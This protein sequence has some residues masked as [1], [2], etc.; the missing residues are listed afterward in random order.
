MKTLAGKIIIAV[1]ALV[2][3]A[4]VAVNFIAGDSILFAISPETYIANL[5]SNTLDG[6]ELM[7]YDKD[8]YEALYG[9]DMT[10]EDHSAL[11]DFK[12]NS[13]TVDGETLDLDGFG[14][15]GKY[16]MSFDKN[17]FALDYDFTYGDKSAEYMQYMHSD[18]EIALSFFG[19][20]LISINARDIL[21]DW[22]ASALAKELSSPALPEG[23][24]DLAFSKLFEDE[25]EIKLPK[26]LLAK[27]GDATVDFIAKSDI[28][29][30]KGENADKI[31][32]SVDAK[33]L[34]EYLV[35][36]ADVLENDASVKDFFRDFYGIIALIESE[37]SDEYYAE[38][39]SEFDL[40]YNATFDDLKVAITDTFFAEEMGDDSYVLDFYE[41]NKKLEG[42]TFTMENSEESYGIDISPSENGVVIA[43][44]QDGTEL[45][46]LSLG[47]EANITPDKLEMYIDATAGNSFF[48]A[49]GLDYDIVYDFENE[50]FSI[51][52]TLGTSAEAISYSITGTCS[53]KENLIINLES[54]TMS[55]PDGE[56]EI[57]CDAKIEVFEG[58]D[59]SSFEQKETVK[60]TNLTSADFEEYMLEGEERLN[61][62]MSALTEHIMEYYMSSYD[63]YDDTYEDDYEYDGYDF[64][65]YEDL[66]GEDEDIFAQYPEYYDDAYFEDF[67][68]Q[69]YGA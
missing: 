58:A 69:Y 21:S 36:L 41:K 48:A 49:A 51:N 52:Y 33:A 5:V 9:F 32:V 37:G 27:L 3:V 8:A 18:D 16:A 35:A 2:V 57:D 29:R 14:M 63:F 44:L 56:I 30:E 24:L 15:T 20:D 17:L 66:Y 55:T 67:Y 25:Y 31:T 7:L 68:N 43:L 60:F 65:D 19:G 4:G 28:T 1:V 39:M 62:I 53:N 59:L 64:Y 46:Q 6:E 13:I 50:V 45:M 54:I 22:N 23:K 26:K 38:T 12:F 10:E 34:G 47:Y 61:E 40:M 11:F 42:F